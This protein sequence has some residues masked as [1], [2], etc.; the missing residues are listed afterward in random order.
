MHQSWFLKF[1]SYTITSNYRR[2]WPPNYPITFVVPSIVEMSMNKIILWINVHANNLFVIYWNFLVPWMWLIGDKMHFKGVLP[3]RSV[4]NRFYFGI[5]GNQTPFHSLLH[6]IK[7]QITN[8][9]HPYGDCE[10]ETPVSVSECKLNCKTKK[11]VE[12]CGCHDVYMKPYET[13][14]SKWKNRG[15]FLRTVFCCTQ[16]YCSDF[17]KLGTQIASV[18]YLNIS[19]DESLFVSAISKEC[20]IQKKYSCVVL[21]GTP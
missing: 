18:I 21:K 8:L 14:D 7:I 6:L 19:Y 5:Y 16:V 11:L 2:T 1:F 12:I 3:K 15:P 4:R 20:S 13:V 9:P 17:M 10:D